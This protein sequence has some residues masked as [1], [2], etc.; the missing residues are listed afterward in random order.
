MILVGSL[1]PQ[2]KRGW[3]ATAS[4]IT[5]VIA[6]VL[7]GVL[8][9]QMGDDAPSTLVGGA[10]AFDRFALFATFTI[11]VSVALA[12]LVVNDYL[13]REGEDGP[14]V[15][16]LILAAAITAVITEAVAYHPRFHCGVSE[17]TRI[18]NNA[19]PSK[20][21]IGLILNH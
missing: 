20:A 2:W 5:A 14:E 19:P 6:A 11:C 7:T 8:W 13:T 3:Y 17:P 21:R 12:S 15:Y 16:G 4:V 1:T 10:L 9:N 18:K